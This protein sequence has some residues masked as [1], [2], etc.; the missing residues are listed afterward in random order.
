MTAGATHPR[1]GRLP[2]PA[3]LVDVDALIGAYYDEAPAGPV[4][5]LEVADAG[6]LAEESGHLR[7]PSPAEPAPVRSELEQQETGGAVDL[8]TRGRLRR[9]QVLGDHG[10]LD[11]VPPLGLTAQRAGTRLAA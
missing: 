4:L 1:A 6:M 7:R 3:T 8:L 5:D 9:G 11:S 10:P 2:D